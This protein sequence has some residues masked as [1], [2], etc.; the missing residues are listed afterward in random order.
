MEEPETVVVQLSAG[1]CLVKRHNGLII[2]RGIPYA[3]AARF[4][5]PVPVPT[6]NTNKNC[7]QP[8][9][10]CPQLPSRL[11]T[12]LGPIT[13]NKEHDEDCLH[14]TI[15]APENVSK[16]PVI[17]FLHGGAFRSRLLPTHKSRS[18]RH[19]LRQYYISSGCLWV[20]CTTWH[21]SAQSWTA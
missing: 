2:A 16:A 17:V 3:K 4:Q 18:T 8:A 6:W 19:G 14:L 1:P 5:T 7:T 10:I 9:K 21:R 11:E 13:A 20:S 15:V 12:V